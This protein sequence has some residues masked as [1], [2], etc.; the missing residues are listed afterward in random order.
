MIRRTVMAVAALTLLFT[1][2]PVFSRTQRIEGAEVTLLEVGDT[3]PDFKLFGVDHRYHSLAHYKDAK[4]ILVIFHC[5]HCPISRG[6]REGLM[7]LAEEFKDKSVQILAI[8]PNPADKSPGDSFPRMIEVAKETGYTF[9]YLYD[10]TQVTA[11]SYG[12]RRTDHVFILGPA[13]DDGQRKI[14]YIGPL[15]NARE[16]PRFAALALNSI[17]RDEEIEEKELDAH[18]CTIK[19]R[20]EEER[21]ARGVELP[22]RDQAEE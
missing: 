7:K 16:E 2:S 14:K 3:A 15:D 9:P 20:N 10:E 19:Y 18:G 8:N 11:A 22:K 17:L 13:D 1:S 6:N 12:A 21:K 5:N 4:A